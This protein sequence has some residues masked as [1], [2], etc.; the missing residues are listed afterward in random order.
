MLSCAAQIKWNII[1]KGQDSGG[2]EKYYRNCCLL[3][4]SLD[5]SEEKSGAAELLTRS[6]SVHVHI[7]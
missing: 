1:D 7:T 2:G 3:R 4:L 5:Y 6:V